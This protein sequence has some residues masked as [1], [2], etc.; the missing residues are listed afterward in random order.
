MKSYF[1]FAVAYVSNEVIFFCEMA[2]QAHD[3][4]SLLPLQWTIQRF[5]D[6]HCFVN[7]RNKGVFS[8]QFHSHSKSLI[9]T[10]VPEILKDS[11]PKQY[12]C[13]TCIHV[14]NNILVIKNSSYLSQSSINIKGF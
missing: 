3:Y 2:K 12:P 13:V 9:T 7:L 1:P 4:S 14:Y 6:W 5:L 8:L 10:Q 11:C